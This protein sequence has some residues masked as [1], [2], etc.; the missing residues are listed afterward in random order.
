MT[1]NVLS[2]EAKQFFLLG[3]VGS[4][5]WALEVYLRSC[6]PDVS[7]CMISESKTNPWFTP[8]SISPVLEDLFRPVGLLAT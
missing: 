5:S 6:F 3:S 4:S 7:G 2:L 8:V 1:A